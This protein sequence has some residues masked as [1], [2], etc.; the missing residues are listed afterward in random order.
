[1][2]QLTDQDA[3]L[4]MPRRSTSPIPEGSWRGSAVDY[5]LVA[6]AKVWNS[7]GDACDATALY[8]QDNHRYGNHDGYLV[9][10]PDGSEDT[11]SWERSAIRAKFYLIA[12]LKTRG[13]HYRDSFNEVLPFRAYSNDDGFLKL[14]S[15]VAPRPPPPPR[16]SLPGVWADIPEPKAAAQSS[17][18]PSRVATD[19]MDRTSLSRGEL[20][21]A[22][23]TSQALLEAIQ[24]VIRDD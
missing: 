24:D 19:L 10:E 8:Y 3:Q 14:E 21:E 9:R 1:M 12:K 17:L 11:G 2:P 18:G 6:N 23:A 16:E 13:S 20:R 5:V 7:K 22:V 15:A 4:P